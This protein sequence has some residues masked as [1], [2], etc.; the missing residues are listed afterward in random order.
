MQ[1]R[2]LSSAEKTVQWIGINFQR[3]IAEG[4][5]SITVTSAHLM[6]CTRA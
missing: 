4:G 1:N 2:R 3:Q 6:Y 5:R